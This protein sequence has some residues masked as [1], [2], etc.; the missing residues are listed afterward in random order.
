[1]ESLPEPFHVIAHRGASAYAPE[2]TLPA[3]RRALELGAFEVELDVRLSR[4]GVLVLFHDETLDAKTNR[5]GPVGDYTA[6]QLRQTEIGSW[7]DREH[8]EVAESF[9]GTTLI[10]LAE[11]FQAFGERLHYQIEIKGKEPAVPR[12][13]LQR[14]REDGVGHRVTASS[15]HR[16]QLDR[17]RRLDGSIPLCLLAREQPRARIDEA[18]RAGFHQLGVRARELS[19][20]LVAEARGR[21]LDVLAFGV[22]TTED[23]ERAIA[24][25]S[26][27]MTVDWPDRLIELRRGA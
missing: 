13:L 3:F 1:M 20:E 22:R 14:V 25:G 11:L 6:A 4:D 10:T 23:M 18:A 15:F 2:N 24:A 16:E 12:L 26:N 7:F 8:P 21:G 9:S 5:R 19:P 27:G 17:V